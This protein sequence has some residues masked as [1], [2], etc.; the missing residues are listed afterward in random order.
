MMQITTES[1]TEQQTSKKPPRDFCIFKGMIIQNLADVPSKD[2]C[3]LC[4]CADGEIVC[5]KRV[6]EEPP[7][8]SCLALPVESNQCCLFEL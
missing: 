5:A 4:Q 7:S 1:V 6:C 2:A 3:E 8:A